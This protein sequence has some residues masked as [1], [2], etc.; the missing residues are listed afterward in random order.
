MF[1]VCFIPINLRLKNKQTVS[2]SFILVEHFSQWNSEATLSKGLCSGAFAAA[3]VIFY[4]NVGWFWNDPKKSFQQH[5]LFQSQVNTFQHGVAWWLRWFLFILQA[6]DRVLCSVF[7]SMNL[8]P[9]YL[10]PVSVIAHILQP[11][12]N[13][14]VPA[15]YFVS[16]GTHCMTYPT[17]ICFTFFT[18]SSLFF[19][20]LFL[21][22][23]TV[24]RLPGLQ[25]GHFKSLSDLTLDKELN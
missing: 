10:Y 8:T 3:I 2:L 25:T 20:M 17:W 18:P 23:N 14:A 12:S 9:N 6:V 22:L 13:V 11:W 16:P 19:L 4:Q 15:P 24:P 5:Q 7:H 21:A 1:Y